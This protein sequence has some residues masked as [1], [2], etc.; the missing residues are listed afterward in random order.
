MNKPQW[1]DRTR[2]MQQVLQATVGYQQAADEILQF[3]E[4]I[5]QGTRCNVG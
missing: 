3:T 2:Q 4:L 5:T 1:R